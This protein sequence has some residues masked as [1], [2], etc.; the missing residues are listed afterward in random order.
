MVL[1]HNHS[2]NNGE[3]ILKKLIERK[4]YKDREP[5]FNILDIVWLLAFISVPILSVLN[6]HYGIDPFIMWMYVLSGFMF[7]RTIEGFY[8]KNKLQM[9]YFSII[10]LVLVGS[11]TL[12]WSFT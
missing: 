11:A 8:N 3:D 5:I 6:V 4:K 1:P 7:L 12:L 9:M 10:G 2:T